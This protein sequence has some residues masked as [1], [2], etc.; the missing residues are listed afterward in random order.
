M[1]RHAHLPIRVLLFAALAAGCNL[2]APVATHASKA[3]TAVASGNAP[4]A[5]A[6]QISQLGNTS[7]LTG[8]VKIIS[9]DGG[10]IISDNGGGIISDNGGGVVSNNSGNILGN[11]GSS[12]VANNSGGLVA[13]N[14]G[15]LTGK[16]KYALLGTKA[17]ELLLAD[18]VIGFYDAAGRQLQDDAG[19]PITV[20]TDQTGAYTLKAVL[21]AG[22]LVMRIQVHDGGALAGG[23]LSAMLVPEGQRTV[24]TP[25]DTSSSLGAA[26]VLGKYVAGDQKTFDKLPASE[27]ERLRLA[28][29]VAGAQLS[30]APTYQ[31]DT[32]IAATEALR[33]KASG[34]DKSL[35]DIQALLLGQAK[36]GDGL[37]ATDVSLFRPNAIA[38]EPDGAIVIAEPLFGRVRRIAADGTLST[39]A[40]LVHG[41]ALRNFPRMSDLKRG[42]DGSLYVVNGGYVYRIRPDGVTV[43]TVAGAGEGATG[44]FPGPATS[45]DIA[46][47]RIAIAPDGLVYLVEIGLD[48][49]APRVFTVD[50]AGQAR[51]VDLPGLKAGPGWFSGIEIAADGTLYLLYAEAGSAKY[52]ILRKKPGGQVETYADGFASASTVADS[53]M[54]LAPDGTIYM[55][56]QGLGHVVAIAPDGKQRIVAGAGAPAGYTDLLGPRSLAVEKDGTLLVVDARSSLIHALT[57]DGRWYVR[58]GTARRGG[59]QG[60]ISLNAPEG[61]VFDERGGLVISEYGSGTLQRFDGADLVPI[62]G[63]TEG[64]AGD[65]G[66]ATAARLFGPT[67]VVIHNGE[68]YFIDGGNHR[69]RAVGKDGTIRSVVGSAGGAIR[70]LAPGQRVDSANF[71]VDGTG[72]AVDKAG[73]VYWAGTQ[74]QVFR[75][76]A[77]GKVELV[78]GKG[79]SAAF[80]AGDPTQLSQYLDPK[81]GDGGPAS[82]GVFVYPT[83][84][85]F[86]A[87][88][89]LYVSDT[90]GMRIR[91]ITG[92]D[93]PTPMISTVAGRPLGELINL[94][95]QDP[96]A[97][98]EGTLAINTAFMAPAGLC[99]GPDGTLY[100][101]E[102][103]T[104]AIPELGSLNGNQLKGIAAILPPITARIRK[105]TPDGVVHTIAGPGGKFF[106]DPK[107]DDGLVLPA[108][109]ALSPDGRLAIVDAGANTVRILPAGQF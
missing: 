14:G 107:R 82:E 68:Y 95:G 41:T 53:G 11:N 106:P 86:D 94:T 62:A 12:I 93:G 79:H 78:A 60:K 57:P 15:G 22:N 96:L 91:K 38:L 20:V 71:A 39:I 45:I 64:D 54:A 9:N 63:T 33:A 32:L 4:V 10:G 23:E 42:P 24:E 47:S 108:A 59:S 84:V 25:I 66:P 13:N 35:K 29:D 104:V 1:K 46:A 103:G 85:A 65:G 83:C 48:A 80:S 19:K 74:S 105:I 92:L 61:G 102:F 72:L 69:I 76:A 73:R 87:A 99:F 27:A 40:D 49:R 90:G 58:A 30:G 51:L 97:V 55:C 17:R 21:P 98:P 50:A 5:S 81:L 70:S 3:P 56:E 44:T 6:F 77:D 52:R 34:V 89:D 31:S 28:L 67:G 88:G 8:K 7:T 16:T 75:L 43:E 36:I 26:Y 100:V 109:V 2:K 101:G 37:Q 18:A